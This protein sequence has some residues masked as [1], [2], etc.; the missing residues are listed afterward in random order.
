LGHKGIKKL[1]VNGTYF[2]DKDTKVGVIPKYFYAKSIDTSQLKQ[3]S[4]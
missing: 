3:Q 1:I 4:I 2:E